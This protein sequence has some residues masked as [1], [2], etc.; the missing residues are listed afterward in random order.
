MLFSVGSSFK[1]LILEEQESL[2]ILGDTDHRIRFY[3]NVMEYSFL[4]LLVCYTVTFFYLLFQL[5]LGQVVILNENRFSVD[6][7]V[8]MKTNIVPSCRTCW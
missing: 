5:P 3:R 4:K 8:F 1:D 6:H 7:F 2:Q